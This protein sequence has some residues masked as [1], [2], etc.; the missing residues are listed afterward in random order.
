MKSE[1]DA[2]TGLTAN[3][4]IVD[5]TPENLQLL[6]GIL[7]KHEFTVRPVLSGEFALQAARKQPPD[8]ILIDARM[9]KMDGYEVCRQLKLDP[10]L[11]EIPVIFLSAHAGIKDKLAAFEVGAVDYITKPFDADEVRS[12]IAIHLE[13]NRSHK[14]ARR[15]NTFLEKMVA[16]RTRELAATN[17]KLAQ[18]DQAKNEFLAAIS[19]ELRTPLSGLLGAGELAFQASAGH[20]EMREYQKMFEESRNRILMFV[21]DALIL[22]NIKLNEGKFAE[23]SS[24]L[25]DVLHTVC[26]ALTDEASAGGISIIP[27]QANLGAV[28]G[29]WFFLERALTRLLLI[30]MKFTQRGGVVKIDALP[31][32]HEVR[33]EILVRGCGIPENAIPQFFEPLA[34]GKKLNSGGDLGLSPAVAAQII[35]LLGGKAEISNL[36]PDGIKL[37]ACLPRYKAVPHTD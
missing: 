24:Q 30:A 8:I 31:V 13:L 11:G 19:H 7:R 26:D 10:K 33:L 17:Q 28:L 27:P 4:L 9:P 25:S 18:L 1:T 6:N 3:I 16:L 23:N 29:D 12:R 22:S 20:P 2:N 14:Q 32:P 37:T 15:Q 34:G 35:N 21:D 5:D 36:S